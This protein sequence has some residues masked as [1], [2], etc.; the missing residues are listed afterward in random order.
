MERWYTKEAR[1]RDNRYLLGLAVNKMVLFG[2]RVM[3][4]HNEILCPFHKWFL[5][6]LEQAPDRPSRICSSVSN[7]SSRARPRRTLSRFNRW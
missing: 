7:S 5:K 4:A 2:G 1:K 6:V 3:L